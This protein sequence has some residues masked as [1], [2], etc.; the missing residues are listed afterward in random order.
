MHVLMQ[1]VVIQDKKI[2]LLVLMN[3]FFIHLFC[4]LSKY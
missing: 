2:L 3:D 1:Y 4:E